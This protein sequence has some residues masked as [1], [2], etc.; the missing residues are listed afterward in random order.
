MIDICIFPIPGAVT[1]PGTVFPLHVFEPRYREMIHHSIETK[2]PIAICHPERQLTE[3]REFDSM[4]QALQSNQAT[5][6]PNDI[7]T[8]G[9]C[10]LRETTSDGRMLVDVHLQRRYHLVEVKQDLPYAIYGCETWEDLPDDEAQQAEYQ[11]LKDQIL[12][13]LSVIGDEDVQIQRLIGSTTWQEKSPE[14]FSFEL[15]GLLRFQPEVMQDLLEMRSVH[16]RLQFTLDILNRVT[17]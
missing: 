13:R 16:Q 10:E 2:M 8:A 4:E 9:W 7:V 15:F 11:E 3:S 17:E 6:Q 1:F 14:A 12:W 5:Y